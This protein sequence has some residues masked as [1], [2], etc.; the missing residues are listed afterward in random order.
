M[1]NDPTMNRDER[2]KKNESAFRQMKAKIDASYPDGHFLAFDDG[3]IVAEAPTYDELTQ[4]L[5]AIGKDRT[6]IF[7]VQAG[8]DYPQYGVILSA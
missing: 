5:K 4:A 2:Y 3:Q 8:V 1:T 6:D 7:V